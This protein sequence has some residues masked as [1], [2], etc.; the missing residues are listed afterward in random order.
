M[1]RGNTCRSPRRPK[2]YWLTAYRKN[3]AGM[4]PRLRGGSSLGAS[5]PEG[6]PQEVHSSV[7]RSPQ[8]PDMMLLVGAK[9]RGHRRRSL[10]ISKN[11]R[12]SQPPAGAL[13]T[14]SAI[15]PVAATRVQ[16]RFMWIL[17]PTHKRD[18]LLRC[19]SGLVPYLESYSFA[20]S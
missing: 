11:L 14:S 4:A 19:R 12:A 7:Y 20:V 13:A 3:Q 2:R 18:R 9:S 8:L 15:R 10:R 6:Q 1:I 17:E 16:E 5:P